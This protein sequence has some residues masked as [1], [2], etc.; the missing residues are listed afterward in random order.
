MPSAPL[1]AVRISDAGLAADS[2]GARLG[3]AGS[4]AD[5]RSS[6]RSHSDDRNSLDL[7]DKVSS[8]LPELTLRLARP[9]IH[10]S[11]ALALVSPRAIRV[12]YRNC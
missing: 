11:A 12:E 5:S 4:A 7:S 3:L 10:T 8:D 2:I 1:E 9:G 6:L